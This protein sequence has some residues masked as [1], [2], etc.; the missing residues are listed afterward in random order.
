MHD[1]DSRRSRDHLHDYFVNT[2]CTLQ[3]IA[4]VLLDVGPLMSPI[5]EFAG[6]AICGFLQSKVSCSLTSCVVSRQTYPPS[7]S[8]AS[9]VVQMLNRPTHE[10]E[11]V[12]FGTTGMGLGSRSCTSHTHKP[13]LAVITCCQ[14]VM[15]NTLY[16]CAQ[17]QTTR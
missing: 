10:V 3:E 15:R 14:V 4:V 17:K 16:V 5:R 8:S 7:L 9:F 1:A 12:F 11:V 2:A 13:Y 6:K